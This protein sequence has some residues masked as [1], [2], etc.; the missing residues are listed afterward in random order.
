MFQL[1][2]I[3][4]LIFLL[5]SSYLFNRNKLT[6]STTRIVIIS[7]L[8]GLISYLVVYLIFFEGFFSF[9]MQFILTFL[10]IAILA[11]I[12]FTI[13]SDLDEDIDLQIET[14]KNN[15]IVF[16]ITIAPFYLSLTIFRFQPVVLQI[17]YSLLVV[18]AILSLYMLTRNKIEQLIEYFFMNIIDTTERALVILGGGALFLIIFAL[19]F[20]IPREGIKQELNLSDAVPYFSSDSL[21]INLDNNF[22]HETHFK[23]SLSKEFGENLIDYYVFD[24]TLYLYDGDTIYSMDPSSGEILYSQSNILKL[25]SVKRTMI[26]YEFFVQ[27]D[28]LYFL[29]SNNLLQLTENTYTSIFETDQTFRMFTHEGQVHFLHLTDY[30]EYTIDKL[31]N[32]EI[33]Y[34]ETV[35]LDNYASYSSFTVIDNT[36]FLSNHYLNYSNYFNRQHTF[37]ISEPPPIYDNQNHIIYTTFYDEVE[38]DT[39][40]YQYRVDEETRTYKRSG[41]QNTLGF[42]HLGN[43]FFYPTLVKDEDTSLTDERNH[44]EIMGDNFEFQ[45]VHS[46]TQYKTFWFANEYTESNILNYHKIDQGITYMQVDQNDKEILLSYHTLMK[47]ETGLNAPFYSHYALWMLIPTLLVFFLPLTNSREHITSIGFDEVMKNKK[48]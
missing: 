36:L 1:Y 24:G 41:L 46:F 33:E 48:Q 7:L 17:L 28:N 19:L 9:I 39:Y 12:L 42:S 47:K 35:T 6:E 2:T 32:N 3:L 15:L 5:V 8:E 37:K 25:N 13:D 21:P 18:A 26:K 4:P 45:V 10:L 20:N 29:S 30:A 14:I 43:A 34:V 23:L 31:N 38:N 44:L 22:K 27:D 40:Y 11:Y 16:F